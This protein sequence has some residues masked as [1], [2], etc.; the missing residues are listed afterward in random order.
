VRAFIVIVVILLILIVGGG[1]T[2][3]LVANNGGGLLPILTTT[4]IPDASPTVVLPWKA[5]QFFLLVGFVLFNL[6]GMAA[7]LALVF[8]LVDRGLRRNQAVGAKAA[9]KRDVAQAEE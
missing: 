9:I 6:I 7:T 3:M 1:L 8:W 5:E 2:A 4:N